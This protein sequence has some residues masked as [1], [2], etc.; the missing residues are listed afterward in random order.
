MKVSLPEHKNGM[1]TISDVLYFIERHRGQRIE[2]DCRVRQYDY[3]TFKPG[4]LSKPQKHICNDTG[5]TDIAP[6][7]DFCKKYN[8]TY[9]KQDVLLREKS[10][11]NN[12]KYHHFYYE[13]FLSFIVPEQTNILICCESAHS[14][15]IKNDNAIEQAYQQLKDRGYGEE[16]VA[17]FKQSS[18]MSML[19]SKIS[20][21]DITTDSLERKLTE[22]HDENRNA[23]KISIYVSSHLVEFS[24]VFYSRIAFA[25]CRYQDINDEKLRATLQLALVEY[26]I[27]RIRKHDAVLSC[28]YNGATESYITG[29][30]NA[31]ELLVVFKKNQDLKQW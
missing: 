1:A 26:L 14:N 21:N 3:Q 23:I 24:G 29:S 2:V 18:I 4:L 19:V 16:K 13:T 8:I 11:G 22:F 30:K 28:E 9:T 27:D 31:S 10:W 25:D 7:L 12:N 15:K 5:E 17:E 20:M 6:I